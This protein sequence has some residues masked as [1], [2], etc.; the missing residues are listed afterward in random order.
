MILISSALH[1]IGSGSNIDS[2]SARARVVRSIL[3]LNSTGINYPTDFEVYGALNQ[4]NFSLHRLNC[5]ACSSFT[6][7]GTRNEVGLRFDNR[8]RLWGVENG[9]DDL[10]VDN[11]TRQDFGDIHLTNPGE[12]V[13]LFLDENINKHYGYPYCWS[14]GLPENGSTY[15]FPQG[16]GA[17]TQWA[18]KLGTQ[19]TDDWCR[20]TTNVVKPRFVMQAHS[21]PLDILF[22]YGSTF[23]QMSGRVAFVSKHGSWD[24]PVSNPSGRSVSALWLDDDGIPSLEEPFFSGPRGWIHRPVGLAVG[25]CAAYGEC[26]FISDDSAGQ[27]IAIAVGNTTQPAP[28]AVAPPT[29]A[30]VL[31]DQPVTIELRPGLNFT[32]TFWFVSFLFKGDLF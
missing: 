9:L 31:Y 6:A 18:T 13:N 27:I 2:N 15:S 32:Y 8:G 24:R 23:P 16:L 29:T 11:E 22:Y 20:N 28:T 19:Y 30:S 7:D 12:E 17:G 1:S 26:L 14:E 21:A 10:G 3:P 25:R 4:A 5:I